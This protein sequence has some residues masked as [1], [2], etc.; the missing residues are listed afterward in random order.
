MGATS[1]ANNVRGLFVQNQGNAGITNAYGVYIEAQSGSPTTN[2]GL[3]N[4]GTSRLDGNVGL[5]TTPATSG[6][7]ITFPATQSASSN[8]NTLDDYE[9]GT[10]T[11]II[12]NS[13]NDATMGASN[14][15]TYTKIG[16]VVTCSM[17]VQ[18]SSLGSI[19]AGDAI[20]LSGWPFTISKS[21]S[22]ALSS[23][24]GFN[25]TAGRV[26]VLAN[27]S[28]TLMRF[29]IWDSTG[30]STTIVGSSLTASTDFYASVTYTV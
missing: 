19:G 26:I 29:Y 10:W 6:T 22:G 2:I 1:T 12:T 14:S 27:W 8:A 30:G 23:A 20:Y 4:G 9:E 7:G 16:R 25:I 15:G 18:V 17:F 13:I 5:N 11:P 28:G 3:Y 21:G 24:S